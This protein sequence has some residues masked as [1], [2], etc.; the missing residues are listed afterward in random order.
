MGVV[1][2][3][4]VSDPGAGVS[5]DDD[6]VTL[7]DVDDDGGAGHRVLVVVLVVLWTWQKIKVN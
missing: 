3:G 1:V 2:H 4:E 6:L 5:V 7:F